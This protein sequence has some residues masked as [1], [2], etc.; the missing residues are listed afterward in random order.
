MKPTKIVMDPDS[1]RQGVHSLRRLAMDG[2]AV[3]RQ[4]K[5]EHVPEGVPPEALSHVHDAMNQLQRSA[6]ATERQAIFVNQCLRL[7]L[8]ADAPGGTWANI[9]LPKLLSPW[10]APKKGGSPF[11]FLGDAVGGIWDFLKGGA[12]ELYGTVKGMADAATTL[13]A[14]SLYELAPGIAKHIPGA[15]KKAKQFEAGFVYAITHPE[16]TLKQL[17]KDAIS[18]KLWKEGKYAEAVGHNVVFFA[19]IFLGFSAVMKTSR[20]ADLAADGER[21]AGA[22]AKVKHTAARGLE[23]DISVGGPQSPALAKVRQ[24]LAEADHA[25]AKATLEQREADKAKAIHDY[26]KAHQKV[27]VLKI[28]A[29][30]SAAMEDDQ[31]AKAQKP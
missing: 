22:L 9:K 17:G 1:M 26:N 14:V 5:G 31:K 4:V 16:E 19:Q 10:P 21:Y 25:R 3:A 6:I 28:G 24:N 23:D 20:A 15:T 29:A 12:G 11:D 2:A 7:G 30:G 8:A 27:D 18:Y 13:A